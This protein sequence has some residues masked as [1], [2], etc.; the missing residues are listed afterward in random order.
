MKQ[1]SDYLFPKGNLKTGSML[2]SKVNLLCIG[3]HQKPLSELELELSRLR[4]KPAEVRMER[5][6][7]KKY[8]TYFTKE[9]Q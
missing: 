9:S 5:D 2:I 1:Q 8:A 3:K 4:S 7:I 6:F